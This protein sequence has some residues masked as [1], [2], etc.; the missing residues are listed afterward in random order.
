MAM[1]TAAI[2]ND[3]VMMEPKIMLQAVS[4]AGD[5]KASLAPRAWSDGLLMAAIPYFVGVLV[6][7]LNTTIGERDRNFATAAALEERER[8]NRIVHDG[9]L[10]VLAMVAR[11]GSELGPRGKMLAVLA[12]KQEDQLRTTLQDRTVDVAQ[13]GFLDASVTDITTML[14]KHQSPT[15]TVS[16]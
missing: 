4:D 6:N 13:G 7:Q 3:G 11:E 15:V 1:I 2:G 10:Q 16:A 14:E 12:R 8:L 5:T 9:V